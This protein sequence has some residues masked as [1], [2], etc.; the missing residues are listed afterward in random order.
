LK[1]FSTFYRN[2][3]TGAGISIIYQANRKYSCDKTIDQ[4]AK[5]GRRVLIVDS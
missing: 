2:R 1:Q 3:I 5:G 4:V